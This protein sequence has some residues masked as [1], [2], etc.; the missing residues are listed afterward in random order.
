ML[1]TDQQGKILYKYDLLEIECIADR[2]LG[3]PSSGF[4]HQTS[5]YNMDYL[6]EDA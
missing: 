4:A 6:S 2:L 5:Y 1:I 3:S